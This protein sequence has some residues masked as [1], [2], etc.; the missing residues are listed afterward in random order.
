MN[1][2]LKPI[3]KWT[4]GK[5]KEIKNFK[6]LIPKYENYCEPFVGGGA[7]YFFLNSEKNIINDF[8]DGLINFY[9]ILKNEFNDLNKL[10]NDAKLI[11]GNHD[12]MEKKYY[13]ERDKLD[14]YTTSNVEKA[15]SFLYVNQLSFSG[16]RRFNKDGKFN[17]PFGHYKNFNPH[18]TSNHLDLLNKTEIKNVDAL[19]LIPQLDQVGNFIFLDPPYTRVFKEYSSKNVFSDLEQE[20]LKDVLANIKFCKW[21]LVIDN[22]EMIKKLYS[23]FKTATYNLKYGVNI[24]NRFNTTTEHAIITNY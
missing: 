5:R 20:K 21:M 22:S 17:V 3:I 10:I 7:L 2:N 18:I 15:F 19:E 24:K 6:H 11:N 16:M 23:N 12:L 13:E 9:N 4:G 8:D 1:K 14:S